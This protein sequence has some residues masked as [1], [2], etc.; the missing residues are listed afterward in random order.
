MPSVCPAG[1]RLHHYSRV[2]DPS[3]PT[4]TQP[5][6]SCP[7]LKWTIPKPLNSSNLGKIF[8]P[9]NPLSALDEA[10]VSPNRNL[11]SM[12]HVLQLDEYHDHSP[13]LLLVG[14]VG[15]SLGV[16]WYMCRRHRKRPRGRRSLFAIKV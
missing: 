15:V 13:S 3:D 9:K 16:V 8:R 4:H 6:P 7:Q 12:G 11:K 1:N 2:L 10:S 5:L 14:I